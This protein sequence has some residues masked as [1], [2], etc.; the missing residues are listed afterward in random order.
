[1]ATD[2]YAITNSKLT[3]KETPEHWN[4]VLEKLKG[5]QMDT[6]STVGPNEEFIKLKGSWEY[7]IETYP[8]F[9]FSVSFGGPYD[10]CPTFYSNTGVISTIYRYGLI[11]N[12]QE[13]YFFSSFRKKLYEVMCLMGGT[14]VIYLADNGCDTLGHCLEFMAWEDTPYETIKSEL[15]KKFGPPKTD[16]A[17]LEMR[18]LDYSKIIE[19]FVDDFTDLKGNGLKP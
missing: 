15:I 11:Y 2:L 10:I 6:I 12:S 9:P 13:I 18:N 4:E 1:M 17:Q 8:D 3:G 14:E 16:Y 19:F 5:L 7:E